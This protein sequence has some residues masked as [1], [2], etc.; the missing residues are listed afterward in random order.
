M[1]AGYASLQQKNKMT[2]DINV[3][4]ITNYRPDNQRSMLRFSSLLMQN[5][6]EKNIHFKEIYPRRK[7]NFSHAPQQMRKWLGYADKFLLFPRKL[8]AALKCIKKKNHVIHVTDH[9]NSLY[10]SKNQIIPTVLTCHDLIAIRTSL[11]ENCRGQEMH[12]KK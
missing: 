12:S 9:S 5:G 4:L 7:L 2:S 11:N 8:N 6:E 3:I 1:D 10:I